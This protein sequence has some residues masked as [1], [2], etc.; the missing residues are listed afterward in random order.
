MLL[1]A[2]ML[3]AF[4]NRFVTP[5]LA[6]ARATE[7]LRPLDAVVASEHPRGA[8]YVVGMAGPAHEL[9][10]LALE[11]A[12]PAPRA[13]V[14]EV[15]AGIRRAFSPAVEPVL[16]SGVM[17][18]DRATFLVE[19]VFLGSPELGGFLS[20][21]EL[22]EAVRAMQLRRQ[23]VLFR[24]TLSA[25]ISVGPHPLELRPTLER[26]CPQHGRLRFVSPASP[27]VS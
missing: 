8:R 14:A 4:R 20:D 13:A 16:V 11:C 3:Q 22:G 9:V 18:A 27:L 5:Y 15:A 23:A 6:L 26:T 17:P 1:T 2:T 12:G 21:I 25:M 10:V 7:L 19:D 24:G